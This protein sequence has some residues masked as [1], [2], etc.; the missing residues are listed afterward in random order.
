MQCLAFRKRLYVFTKWKE[1]NICKQNQK[2]NYWVHCYNG[3]RCKLFQT[4]HGHVCWI[5]PSLLMKHT[6]EI[7]EIKEG[8]EYISC[9]C[10]C[11]ETRDHN[12]K[13]NIARIEGNTLFFVVTVDAMRVVTLVCL[14]K[15][16]FD[17]SQAYWSGN[18]RYEDSLFC[19]TT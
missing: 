5:N 10:G 1:T 19:C 2:P 9:P 16:Q 13:W 6:W 15:C 3:H 12:H 7:I 18:P 14:R 4:V 17:T 8:K 11:M